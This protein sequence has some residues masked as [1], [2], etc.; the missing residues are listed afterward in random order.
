MVKIITYR[1]IKEIPGLTSPIWWDAK[2]CVHEQFSLNQKNKT[3]YST[4]YAH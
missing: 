2:D 3:T 1:D 4:E